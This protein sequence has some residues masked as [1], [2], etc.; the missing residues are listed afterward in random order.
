MMTTSPAR[1]RS[2][3]P[4][5][6][7]SAPLNADDRG[8][9]DQ[10]DAQIAMGHELK[11]WWTENRDTRVRL[12]RVPVA[13]QVHE[14]DTNYGFIVD[15]YLRSGTLPIVGVVQDQAFR[16]PK[17]P[18]SCARDPQWMKAQ[19]RAFVLKYFM[20]MAGTLPPRTGTTGSEGRE[21]W[22]Y[23]QMYYK[24]AATGAVGKFSPAQQQLIVPLDDVGA[25]Y[26][27]IVFL[28]K[29]HQ[30]D[31]SFGIPGVAN[32][33]NVTLSMTQPV[34]TVMAPEFLVD[35]DNPEPG[36]LGRYGYGYSVVPDL[37]HRTAITSGPSTITN[38]IEMLSF[39]VLN[40]GEV[41]AHMEF[42]TPQPPRIVDPV[43][44]AFDVADRLSFGTASKV[45]GP[46]KALLERMEPN[47]DPIYFSIAVLNT[48]SAGLAAQEFGISKQN[49]FKKFMNLH[50]T[51]VYKMYNL[52]ASHFAMVQDWTD[53]STLPTWA[54]TGVYAPPGDPS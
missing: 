24:L 25:K 17:L 51:D 44:L 22:G 45:F 5:D 52:A 10:V 39:R 27:W 14:P 20:R 41:R 31:M 6:P 7:G 3:F 28:V 49:L 26:S 1:A 40:T 32:G 4:L 29:I 19:L 34:H 8:I 15:A 11:T 50:F 37:A 30:F 16:W 2:E 9:L 42:I 54:T 12:N 38:T 53:T 47:V 48:L 36:V 13:R 18:P 43:L 33:P 21:G 46:V 23:R 35:E